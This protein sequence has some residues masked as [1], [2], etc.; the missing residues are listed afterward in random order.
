[1][2]TLHGGLNKYPVVK[3]SVKFKTGQNQNK[4]EAKVN[5]Q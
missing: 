4:M 2:C 3:D 5:R 1:M